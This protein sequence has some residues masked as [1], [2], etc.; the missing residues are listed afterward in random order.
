MKI[1]RCHTTCCSRRLMW[2]KLP[3]DCTTSTKCR[4]LTFQITSPTLSTCLI[5][6]TTRRYPV[7]LHFARLSI[8]R[9]KI[10]TSCSPTGEESE[11]RANTNKHHSP[12]RK[13]PSKNSRRFSVRRPETSG[14]RWTYS[15]KSTRRNT[16][17][18]REKTDAKDP[19]WRN[20]RLTWRKAADRHNCLRIFRSWWRI[21]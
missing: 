19:S 13:K 18:F 15:S 21:W 9:E 17:W 5:R 8:R 11:T 6:G 20:W 14:R 1:R 7:A 12:R 2:G 4:W 3:G 10:C 16:G